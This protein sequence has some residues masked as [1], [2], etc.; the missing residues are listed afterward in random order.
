MFS[1]EIQ[2]A[3]ASGYVDGEGCIYWNLAKNQP[4]KRDSGSL[5][6]KVKSGDIK[7]LQ[8]LYTLFGGSIAEAKATDNSK[9]R[10]YTWLVNGENAYNALVTL[11]PYLLVKQAQAKYAT[12]AYLELIWL[13]SIGERDKVEN[14]HHSANANLRILKQHNYIGYDDEKTAEQIKTQA[15]EAFTFRDTVSRDLDGASASES[16]LIF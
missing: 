9:V 16:H 5:A 14:L 2:I 6:L 3:R 7:N 12:N 10:C 15:K 11:S 1:R 8:L 13:R 4:K